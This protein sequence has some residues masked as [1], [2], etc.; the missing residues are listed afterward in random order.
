M[1]NI[2]II[3]HGSLG[4]IAQASGAIQDIFENH[5]KDK[6]Y[7]LTTKPYIELF[8][9]NPFIHD[10]ILDKRLS[11]FNIFYLYFLMRNIKKFNFSKVYDLQ[12]STRTYFYKRILFPNSNKEQWSSSET[13]L[14][15]DTSKNDFDKKPVLERF[16]HQLKI[17]KLK[18]NHTLKPDFSW[19]YSDIT[20]IKMQYNLN[21]YIILFPFCSPHLTIKKWP[22]FN[23]LIEKIKNNLD[24][25]FKI[26]IAPG[27][28][29]IKDASDINALCVLNGKKSLDILQLSS[30]IKDSSFVVANDTGPAHMAAHLGVKGLALYGSHVSA[31]L[32][33][34]ERE[35]F[36]TIQVSDLSKLSV[37]KVFEKISNII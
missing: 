12:N 1:S 21:R 36:K 2:L 28:N 19:S 33:S 9:K 20:Q 4:D 25:D 24:Q 3:K 32:Q 17:S 11:R 27:Q 34:I 30:L 13:T 26:I 5:K 8:R 7:L 18:T 16:N 35:N 37:D 23:E 29:E 31:R 22:Y 15:Q 14:P 6:I 10:I